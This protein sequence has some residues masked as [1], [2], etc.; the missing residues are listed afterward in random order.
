MEVWKKLSPVFK[1]D[2]RSW[3][4]IDDRTEWS[5][6]FLEA[7]YAMKWLLSG[8]DYH[9]DD[10]GLWWKPIQRCFRV[11]AGNTMLEFEPQMHTR[12]WHEGWKQ[13]RHLFYRLTFENYEIW[14]LPNILWKSITYCH[15]KISLGNLIDDL[16]LISNLLKEHNATL[17]NEWTG[18]PTKITWTPHWW[19]ICIRVNTR[20]D[21]TPNTV[22][23]KYTSALSSQH[24][25]WWYNYCNECYND[26]TNPD[27]DFFCL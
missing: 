15:P 24:T 21:T 13:S 3:G 20:N 4:L 7:I 11:Y 8:T 2:W 10:L 19:I 9:D 23:Q 12:L 17:P 1:P 5:L 27:V 6:N 14:S 16:P 26:W 22:A 25:D 18:L